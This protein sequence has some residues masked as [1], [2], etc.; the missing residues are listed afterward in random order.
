MKAVILAG[1]F[2]TR[3][4]PLTLNIPKP[5][6]KLNGKVILDM[7]IEKVNELDVDE[8]I[9]TVNRKFYEHFIE[10]LNEREYKNIFLKV[11]EATKEEEKPGAIKALSFLLN[12]LKNNDVIV[13]AGDNLFTDSLKSI[14]KYYLSVD[15]TTIAIYDINDLNL[16][17]KYST[18][19]SDKK[20]RIISFE[21]KP[22]NPKTTKV[23]T[24]IYFFKNEHFQMIRD[25]IATNKNKDSP[26][27][28]IAWL[29]ERV[30][31]YAYELKG[32]WLDI[33]SYETYMKAR[34]IFGFNKH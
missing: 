26:G 7:I 29:V 6:L 13:I 30:P 32:V 22:K 8:I 27:N 33:G 21:E 4:Y 23:G 14:Y 25:Y 5:L 9:L 16:V 3:L 1:G 18:I 28:F 34:E 17:K 31:V 11:E 10:W 12:D 19:I 2:A 15:S 20:S 24:G